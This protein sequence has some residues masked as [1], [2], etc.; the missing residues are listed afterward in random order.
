[1]PTLIKNIIHNGKNLK[2]WCA[3]HI[4]MRAVASL[5]F[6]SFSDQLR[7]GY[8]I[9]N[10]DWNELTDAQAVWATDNDDNVL[11]GI[12][13]NY[14]KDYFLVNILCV[15]E[16]HEYDEHI[17]EHCIEHLKVLG[18]QAEMNGFFQIVHYQDTKNIDRAAKL[19]MVSTFHIFTRSLIND[20]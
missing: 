4:A 1:M 16:N 19:N 18:K 9:P 17:H 3:D 12:C 20:S 5:I 8:I 11:G 13:F 7:E 10:M 6:K 15:F 14:N 2:F